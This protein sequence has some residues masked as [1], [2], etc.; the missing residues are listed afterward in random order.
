[1]NTLGQGVPENIEIG[2]GV[3]GEGKGLGWPSREDFGDEQ[4][5]RAGEVGV[6]GVKD[7]KIRG[8]G[9]A[10]NVG[11]TGGIDGNGIAEIIIITAQVG[12]IKG[13]GGVGVELN[14]K[15]IR[16][17]GIGGEQRTVKAV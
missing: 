7:R 14:D 6:V 9:L 10:Q 3:P 16:P 5:I 8:I 13:K 2:A 4:R 15:S 1:M 12:G 11:V 17:A